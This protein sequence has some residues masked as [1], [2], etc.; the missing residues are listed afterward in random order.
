MRLL[1]MV[2]LATFVSIG[3]ADAQPGIY[4]FPLKGEDLL[5][6]ERYQTDRHASGI[7]ALGKDIVALR[8]TAGTKWDE[9]HNGNQV[10]NGRYVVYDKK[11]YAMAD[12]EVVG[13]WRNAPENEPG[14]THRYLTARKFAGGGNHLWILQ[15]DGIYALYAHAIPGSIPAGLCPHNATY[16]TGASGN[17]GGGAGGLPD[18]E[19]EVKVAAGSREVCRTWRASACRRISEVIHATLQQR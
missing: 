15:T 4:S 1:A 9:F 12:R 8:H 3:V 18:I 5:A 6:S 2:C 13:C 7:Q 16:F 11:F 19:N 14:K 17:G 10:G